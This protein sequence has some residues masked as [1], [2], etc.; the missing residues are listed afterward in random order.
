MHEGG[1]QE[2]FSGEDFQPLKTG[3]PAWAALYVFRS[4]AWFDNLT[5]SVPGR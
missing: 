2:L 4:V 1:R 5:V 3:S